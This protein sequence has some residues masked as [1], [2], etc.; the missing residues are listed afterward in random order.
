MMRGV[1]AGVLVASLGMSGCSR[2]DGLTEG[3]RLT[4]TGWFTDPADLVG[5]DCRYRLVTTLPEDGATGWYWR[6][7]LTM[8]VSTASEDRYETY[9]VDGS[10]VRL[11][12]VPVW[13]DDGLSATLSVD[14]GLEAD[15]S[16]AWHIRDCLEERVLSFSTSELGAPLLGG[17]TSLKGNTYV[18]DL[19]SADWV[20]PAGLGPVLALYFDTPILLGVENATASVLEF[21]GAPGA[22]AAAGG[23]MQ[24][25]E[26]STWDFGEASFSQAPYFDASVDEVVFAFQGTTV[27]VSSFGLTGT[28]A[29]DGSSLGGVRL[30]GLADTRQLGALLGDP[31]N[32]SAL[33]DY[34]ETLGLACDPCDDGEVFCMVLSVENVTAQQ[35]EGL[36]LVRR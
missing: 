4:D 21:I 3:P 34:A 15:E 25:R 23:L 32:E 31:D 7:P 36:E 12:T 11:P 29:A 22:A 28:F 27:P 10:G 30:G 8:Y 19:A 6:D 35:A 14:G 20:Q 2:K 9:L 13:T 18:L 24:D 5:D 1:V 17:A 16:Y 33:C 26:A